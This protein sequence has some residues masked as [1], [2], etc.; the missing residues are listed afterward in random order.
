MGAP[1]YRRPGASPVLAGLVSAGVLRPSQRVL[2]IGCGSGI[3]S[4]ALAAWGFRQVVGI[5]RCAT[6][7]AQARRRATV[8]GLADQ[9]SFFVCAVNEL[10]RRCEPELFDVVLDSLCWNNVHALRPHAT[11]AFVRA[12][13]RVLRPGGLYILQARA[14]RHPLAIS[15]AS[16][17][18]PRSF[19][20]HFRM[21][22]VITTHMPEWFGRSSVIAVSVGRRRRRLASRTRGQARPRQPR[23]ESPA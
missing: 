8:F 16:R 19:E 21:S 18:L 4:V 15:P 11:P 17:A 3:D 23:Q 5:D 13:A 12:V 1:H 20:R 9:T 10:G 6:K 7:V 14:D 22:D 2:D